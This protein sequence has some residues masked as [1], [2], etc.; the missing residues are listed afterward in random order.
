[1]ENWLEPLTFRRLALFLARSFA[2]LMLTSANLLAEPV[3]PEG[4]TELKLAPE[5]ACLLPPEETE[6]A[7]FDRRICLTRLYGGNR[8]TVALTL[9]QGR[10]VT[11]SAQ[12]AVHIPTTNINHPV[13]NFAVEGAVGRTPRAGEQSARLNS[14]EIELSRDRDLFGLTQV[15]LRARYE[16]DAELG[17]REGMA[18]LVFSHGKSASQT[19]VGAVPWKAGLTTRYSAGFEGGLASFPAIHSSVGGGV[20]AVIRL[21]ATESARYCLSL[22]EKQRNLLCAGGSAW[23]KLGTRSAAGV[24][25]QVAY[26][27]QVSEAGAGRTYIYLQPQVEGRI[28]IENRVQVGMQAGVAY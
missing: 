13:L 27:R 20:E 14:A 4:K 18:G 1:M 11:L 5:L 16:A 6:D 2:A 25:G 7:R 12:G 10:E 9:K 28:S 21:M 15:G 24:T 8:G 22:D 17:T 3:P 26:A 23:Q 19:S